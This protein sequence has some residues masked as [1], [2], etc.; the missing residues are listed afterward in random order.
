MI[1]DEFEYLG[2]SVMLMALL[3]G[4]GSEDGTGTLE[5]RLSGEEASRQGF[6]VGSGEDTIAF[7]DGYTLEFTKVLV[8]IA[9]VELRDADGASAGLGADSVV[10]DLHLG[11]PV[12][13][14]FEGVPAQRWVDVRYRYAPPPADARALG[15]VAAADVDRMRAAGASLLIAGSATDGVETYPFELLFDGEVQ[16]SRCES[17]IDETDGLVIPQNGVV[18]AELTVHLDHLF[19]DTYAD[20]EADLRFEAWAA[21]IG[22]DETITL[23]D[24][25][26]QPLADLRDRSGQPIVE[27]GVQ[28]VYDPGPLDLERNDLGAYVRAATA[29][30]GH[31]QG[32][33]HCDYQAL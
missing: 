17:G 31:F 13:W 11:E 10:A 23:D 25:A 30:T 18:Q 16:M 20:D 22:D 14:T 6:P 3:A 32:E 33:G 2:R 5:L 12:A 27:D 1:R 19:F 9:E 21:A 24:L 29:T 8:S 7:A 4:C 28:V 15:D 26:T